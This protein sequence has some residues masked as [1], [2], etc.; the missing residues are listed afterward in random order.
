MSEMTLPLP[1]SGLRPRASGF[2]GGARRG[3]TS[4]MDDFRLALGAL[5]GHKLRSGL[6]LLGIVIGVFT[7]VSMMALPLGFL[8]GPSAAAASVACWA[9]GMGAQDATLRSGISQVVSMNKRGS[10]FG[11]FN[12]VYGVAWFVGSAFMGL[13]Y[14]HSVVALVAFGVAAQLA[15]AAMFFWLRNPL[16]AAAAAE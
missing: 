12:A 3:L 13:L 7:V 14:D 8:G 9:V 4:R 15:A 11:A 10:A 16:A 6:T 2:L 1:A 5:N